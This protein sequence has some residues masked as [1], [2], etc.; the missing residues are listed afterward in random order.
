MTEVELE[1]AYPWIPWR[2]PVE[3]YQLEMGNSG[4]LG[5]GR[6]TEQHYQV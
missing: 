5:E 3:V 2:E 1:K 4:G 6:V